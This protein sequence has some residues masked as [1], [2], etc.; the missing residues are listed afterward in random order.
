MTTAH[1]DM[2]NPVLKELVWVSPSTAELSWGV[3]AQQMQS[4]E[5]TELCHISAQ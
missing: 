2:L 3:L 5:L 4:P 1:V